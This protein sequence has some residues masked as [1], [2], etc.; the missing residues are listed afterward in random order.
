LG[1][2]T[3]I[4]GIVL[5]LLGA[6]VHFTDKDVLLPLIQYNIEQNAPHISKDKY[7]V[8]ELMWGETEVS[9]KYDII[10]ACDCVY[11]SQDMWMPLATCLNQI[12]TDE[13]DVIMS[14]ELRS[15]KDAAFFPHISKTFTIRKVLNTD[16]D[17]FWQSPDIGVFHLRKRQEPKEDIEAESPLG[18]LRKR[19]RHIDTLF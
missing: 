16:L 19:E 13:T 14:Y 4:I 9:D 6:E 7:Q 11:E 17:E 12:A 5:L 10:V 2:G 18:D 15:K 8:K 1:A 3:G